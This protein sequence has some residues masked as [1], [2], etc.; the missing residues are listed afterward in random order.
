MM[1]AYK[2]NLQTQIQ[3]WKDPLSKNGEQEDLVPPMTDGTI[4]IGDAT[5][6]SHSIQIP[7]VPR[8]LVL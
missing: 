7:Q 5:D 2:K 1:C 6:Q 8:H 4:T 3:A